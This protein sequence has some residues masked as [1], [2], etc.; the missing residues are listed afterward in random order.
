[1]SRPIGERKVRIGIIGTGQIGHQHLHSY[2]K[3]PQA[4]VVALADLYEVGLKAAASEFGV[5]SVYTDYEEL[6]RREDIDAVDVC[7]HN[8]LHAPVT[9]AA[10]RAGKHVYCEKPIAASYADGAAMLAAARETGNMLSIQLA[11]LYTDRIRAARELIEA[12]ELGELYHARSAGFRR[13]GRP[14]VD[15]YGAPAF[16]QTAQAGGGALFDMGVYH[17]SAMLYLLGN[18]KIERICGR[19]HQKIAMDAAR[20]AS[21]GYDVEEFA[22]GL[23]HFE[24]GAT[25]DLVEAWAAHLDGLGNSYLLGSEGGLQME[26]FSFHKNIGDL[27]LNSTI[28]LDA[29]NFRWSTLRGGDVYASSQGHWVAALQGRV[30]LLPTAEIALNTMLVSEGIYQSSKQNREVRAEEIT[31]G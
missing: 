27:A 9:I 16:V 8:R 7:L 29:A 15:G 11:G 4:E 6:L 21:S 13:R 26:P 14:F 24:G 31:G 30:A 23:V 5:E 28:D 3:I 22:I 2:A 10:L 20:Q 19:T 12:G 1:M 18:P 25:L 17:I